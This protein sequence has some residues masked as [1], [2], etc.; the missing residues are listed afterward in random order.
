M[1]IYGERDPARAVDKV[2][3]IPF[4]LADK[5]HFLVAAVLG[6]EGGIGVRSGCFC[7]HPYVVHLLGLSDDERQK[8]RNRYLGGDKS[9]MPGMIRVSFGCYNDAE[10]VDRLVE[11]LLRIVKGD[12]RGDY[13][14]DAQTG[15]FLPAGY[16]EP[17][18]DFFL[19][20]TA[21]DGGEP[22]RGRYCGI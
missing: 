9:H 3:V 2:G 4:N 14:D 21:P 18:K 13:R 8:W 11:M 17:L 19:L 10:D 22:S 15:E 16:T 12:Y 5:S 6:Y 7:A 1:K 20:E